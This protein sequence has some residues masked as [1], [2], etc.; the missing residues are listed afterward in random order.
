MRRLTVAQLEAENRMLRDQLRRVETMAETW[1]RRK[2]ELADALSE[3]AP[4]VY[5]SLVP[6]SARAVRYLIL[7]RIVDA[8]TELAMRTVGMPHGLADASVELEALERAVMENEHYWRDVQAEKD[9]ARERAERI[10]ETKRQKEQ[11]AH[12]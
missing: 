8:A 2:G 7:D 10:K 6:T 1:R 3:V 5:E 9:L 4:E 12:G 11:A